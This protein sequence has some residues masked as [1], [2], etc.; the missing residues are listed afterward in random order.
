[1]RY[2]DLGQ[3]RLRQANQQVLLYRHVF[4]RENPDEKAEFEYSLGVKR[5]KDF[6]RKGLL[7]FLESVQS[8]KRL[9]LPGDVVLSSVAVYDDEGEQKPTRAGRDF[10]A[11]FVHA[12]R[13]IGIKQG[14]EIPNGMR[15]GSDQEL[16]LAKIFEGYPGSQ[17]TVWYTLDEIPPPPGLG[18]RQLIKWPPGRTP[19][20]HYKS[21]T[22]ELL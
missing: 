14:N 2:L 10:V 12:R 8:G 11:R 20:R 7:P 18:E 1:M 3:W 22:F 15:F 9:G 19:I 6:E 13:V 5:L 21:N 17:A 16:I 4:S